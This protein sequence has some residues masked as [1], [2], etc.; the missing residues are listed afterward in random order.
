MVFQVTDCFN[1]GAPHPQRFSVAYM[2]TAGNNLSCN[3]NKKLKIRAHVREI[4]SH[5]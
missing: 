2:A 4:E 5:L 3:G 1:K